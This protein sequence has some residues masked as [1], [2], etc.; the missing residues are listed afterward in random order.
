MIFPARMATDEQGKVFKP[1][2]VPR[3]ASRVNEVVKVRILAKKRII[4]SAAAATSGLE[5]TELPLH[6]KLLIRMEPTENVRIERSSYDLLN[7]V[8]KSFS[9]ILNADCQNSDRF[10]LVAP[11]IFLASQ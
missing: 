11:S 1:P 4:Q 10:F 9:A 7:S 3:S 8:L 6:A 5:P 2:S